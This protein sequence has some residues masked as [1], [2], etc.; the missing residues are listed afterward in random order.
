[1]S[2]ET[3]VLLLGICTYALEARTPISGATYIGEDLGP[4]RHGSFPEQAQPR[5]AVSLGPRLLASVHRRMRD[6]QARAA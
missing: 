1:M 4:I 3:Y 2:E 6:S 5:K